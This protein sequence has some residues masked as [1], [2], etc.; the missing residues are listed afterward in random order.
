VALM[1]TGAYDKQWPDVHMQP[2]QTL[3]AFLDVRGK[4]LVPVHNGTF[5]LG[6]HRWQEPFDRI[7]ALVAARGVSM[8]TPEMGEALDLKGPRAGRAWWRGVE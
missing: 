6:L 5:D 8:A 3:Q 2:E 1:E 4:W 7:A